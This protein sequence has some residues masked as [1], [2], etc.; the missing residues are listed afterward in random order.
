[1]A[2]R[3]VAAGPPRLIAPLH[4]HHRD[5]EAWYVLEELSASRRVRTW[6]KC[7][8]ARVLFMGRP[9]PI[10]IQD[11]AGAISAH[12]DVAYFGLIQEIHA[13]KERTPAALAAMFEKHDSSLVAPPLK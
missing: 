11:R 6:W 1:M 13:M 2:R 3:P 10:G 4:V 8:W 9:T 5:D 7:L 12:H